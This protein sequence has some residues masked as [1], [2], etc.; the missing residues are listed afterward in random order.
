MPIE[1]NIFLLWL[2]GWDKASWLNYQVLESWKINNPEWTIHLIDLNNLR[3][4]VNDIDYIYDTNKIISP[5]TKSDIIRL[6]L[7][8]NYGGV[9]AD[10]TLLC[11]QPLDFWID[12][13]C[14]PAEFWM[15]HGNGG[16]LPKEIGPAIW[17]IVSKKNNYIISKWKE[18]S[19]LYWSSNNRTN[20]YF[21]LDGLFKHLIENDELFKNIWSTVPY[22]YCN[23]DGQ[24]HTLAIHKMEANTEHIK[25]LFLEKPPYV[26][27]LWRSW[28]SLFPDI[29]TVKCQ[30][31]NGF[32]AIQLSKR[33]YTYKHTMT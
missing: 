5:Q 4:Y 29:N 8:K 7:L 13:A 26:L 9:W 25:K 10:A 15:Y 19:D 12:E 30:N 20:N 31:S 1:R 28:N 22:L 17:F 21:W 16:G 3:N 11:M 23:L 18:Q 14:S 2:Q 6:S 24:S 32:C 33:K 27:K